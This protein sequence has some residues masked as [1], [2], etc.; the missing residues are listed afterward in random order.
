VSDQVD[1]ELR[2][3]RVRAEVPNPEGVLKPNM[4]VQGF[5]RIRDPG[6]ERLVVPPD[7][8]QLHEGHT[9]VFVEVAAEPGEEHRLFEAREVTAGEVLTEGQVVLSG[10][11][12]SDAV[13]TRG[14]FL[15]KAELTK[16]AGGHAH[17]H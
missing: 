6:T 11:A 4:Y 2:T 17:V 5:L 14:A 10:L 8:V 1:P 9:V 12:G 13:V 7:A 15:L 3:V 16:G